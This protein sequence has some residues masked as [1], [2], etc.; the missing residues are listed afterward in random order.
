MVFEIWVGLKDKLGGMIASSV[1]FT[2][3]DGLL[4]SFE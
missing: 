3:K 2:T 1:M 4:G